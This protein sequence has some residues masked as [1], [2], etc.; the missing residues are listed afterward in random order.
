MAYWTF[1]ECDL[2]TLRHS[3]SGRNRKSCDG[4][5]R[6]SLAGSR[7]CRAGI[8]GLGNLT[9]RSAASYARQ[10]TQACT[11]ECRKQCAG[12]AHVR[13]M[14]RAP[15]RANPA[16]PGVWLRVCRGC[17]DLVRPLVLIRGKCRCDV[18]PAGVPSPPASPRRRRCRRSE[19]HFFRF[20]A[21]ASQHAVRW[22]TRQRHCRN[23]SRRAGASPLA[24][25]WR[26]R[27]SRA[28]GMNRA[29]V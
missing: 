16:D 2:S 29:I 22:S 26:K 23:V 4:I 20:R 10:C 6:R 18:S 27:A 24:P 17:S 5:D 14:C 8:I 9:D 3:S 7:G 15:P 19:S 25:V 1:D 11:Q 21:A 12:I 28:L 13:H